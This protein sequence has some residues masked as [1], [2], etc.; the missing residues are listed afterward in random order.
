[1]TKVRFLP[2]VAT[3][4]WSKDLLTIQFSGYLKGIG[5]VKIGSV[6]KVCHSNG[7]NSTSL[8]YYTNRHRNETCTKFVYDRR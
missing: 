3:C 4:M 8:G 5:A 7:F 1:M 2:E 6:F